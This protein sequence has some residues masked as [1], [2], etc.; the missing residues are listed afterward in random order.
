SVAPQL[1]FDLAPERDRRRLRSARRAAV[2][3][4]REHL[5]VAGL[6]RPRA[7]A[8]PVR[9]DDPARV[10]RVATVGMNAGHARV[11]PVRAM[12]LVRT[13]RFPAVAERAATAVGTP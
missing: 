13:D 5:G 3:D 4:A 12:D 10:L 8:L 2:V 6:E 1:A 11:F 9:E 7:V